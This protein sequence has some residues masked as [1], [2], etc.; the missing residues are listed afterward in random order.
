[1]SEL[2]WRELTSDKIDLVKSILVTLVKDMRKCE[3]DGRRRLIYQR[4]DPLA[5]HQSNALQPQKV[6]KTDYSSLFS[7]APPEDPADDDEFT[8]SLVRDLIER[9][10]G[11]V[12]IPLD[13]VDKSSLAALAQ[14]VLEVEASRRS[15]DIC[16]LRYLISIRAFANRDRRAALSGAATPLPIPIPEEGLRPQAHA[17]ISFRNIVWAT[18]SESHQV[19]LQAAT[20]ATEDNKMMWEDAKRLGVFLWLRSQDSI[21][22]QLEVVARN[23]FM[24]EEDRDPISASLIFFALGKKQVVHGLWRQAPGHKEQQMMLKFLANDFTLDRWKTAAAKNAY[25]LLS[26]Q[27]YEYAA[28]FFMLAGNPKDAITV[29]LRQLNDWQLAVALA[30]AIEGDGPLLKWILADTVLPIAFGGGHRWLASWTLWMLN[31]RDLSVRVIISP[32]EEVAAAWNAEAVKNGKLVVGQPDNDDPSL[33]LLFQ[34]LKSKTLQTAKGTSEITPVLEFDFVV[35][36]ARVF[37]RMGCHPLGLDLLRS[38]S[39]ERPWFPPPKTKPRPEPIKV[40]GEVGKG[41]ISPA[42]RMS[43]S[44][45]TPRRRSSF[46][47][48]RPAGR[49]NMLMDMDVVAEGTEPPTRQP[50]PTPG[51]HARPQLA[52]SKPEER[53][54]APGL[55][56]GLRQDVQQGAAEFDMDT[57]FAPDKPKGVPELVTSPAST[58][59]D[60]TP[61]FMTAETTPLFGVQFADSFGGGAA[62]GA[63]KPDSVS[64]G[65]PRSRALSPGSKSPAGRTPGGQSPAR[66]GAGTP[67]RK[68][69]NLMKEVMA[70]TQAEQGGTEFS[71]DSFFPSAAP[72]PARKAEAIED[73]APNE[74]GA[75]EDKKPNDDKKSNEDRSKNQAEEDME[76]TKEEVRKGL[77][78]MKENNA[79]TQSAQG[80]AEFSFDGFTGDST[81][82]SAR[83]STPP[84]KTPPKSSSTP[85]SPTAPGR[86]VPRADVDD[87]GRPSNG[88]KT[89]ETGDKPK[90]LSLMK[91]ANAHTQSAQGGAEFSLDSFFSPEAA[92]K[93]APQVKGEVV[94]EEAED[95]IEVQSKDRAESKADDNAEVTDDNAAVKSEDTPAAPDPEA[96]PPTPSSS[97]TPTPESDTPKTTDVDSMPHTGNETDTNPATPDAEP[98]KGANLMKDL[99]PNASAAQGGTEFSFDAFGF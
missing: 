27:R 9:L 5:F 50:S 42:R 66:S 35:H 97:S 71:F 64:P 96:K 15:L 33:L 90:G 4:L 89:E 28:A 60:A 91:E 59:G 37:W 95:K 3:D 30:R 11:P 47:L 61:N 57:F 84:R 70:G 49:E 62:A 17:R 73:N 82:A 1:M 68:G 46:M 55:M 2:K 22:A 44:P 29:C 38:W 10:D 43:T 87:K 32:M 74:S 65:S 83:Q 23:R 14:A 12:V 36:N 16:G 67:A 79:H 72:A 53:T 7:I 92:P 63:R 40:D 86:P 99:N 21:R 69:A 20:A 94:A 6:T 19:L 78:L 85:S 48:A 45:Y 25:A 41:P 39:F 52:M 26:K 56:K 58:S 81:P 80:G 13:Q 31:R 24:S 34:H 88:E 76:E 93:P 75:K 51:K 98:R 77:S 54:Q 18:H 8:E